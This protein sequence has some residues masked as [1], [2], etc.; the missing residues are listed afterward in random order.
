VADRDREWCAALIATADIDLMDRI[1]RKFN[2]S[3][4]D[5]GAGA[6]RDSEKGPTP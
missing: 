1:L 5:A 3:R 4:S 2:A 6:P